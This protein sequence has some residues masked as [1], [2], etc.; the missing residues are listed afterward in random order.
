MT[1]DCPFYDIVTHVPE[2]YKVC[3]KCRFQKVKKLEEFDEGKKTCN[4]CRQEAS[5]KIQCKCGATI[6]KGSLYV[7]KQS[8]NIKI[9]KKVWK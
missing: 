7:H 9:G 2:G 5:R 6:S 1:Y 8:K 3:N 4:F